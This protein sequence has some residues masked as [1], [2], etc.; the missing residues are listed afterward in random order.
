MCGLVAMICKY[1]SGFTHK[2]LDIFEQL[3]YVDTLRG[4]DSTGVFAVN[5]MGNVGIAKDAVTAENFLKTKE[6]KDIRSHMFREG[7]ALVGH[8]RKATRGEIV[9]D[10]AHPF[11]DDNEKLVLVHNGSYY[12][13]HRKL[14]DTTVDS[15]AITK[16]LA[17]HIDNYAE[18]LRKVNAAYALIFYDT[19]NKKLNIIRN[20]DRPLWQVE[21]DYAYFFCSE[22]W[23]LHGVIARN[24]NKVKEKAAEL[25]PHTLH[26]F[27]LQDDH[28]TNVSSEKLDCTFRSSYNHSEEPGD[29]EQE[30]EY[31]ANLRQGGWNRTHTAWANYG[32]CGNDPV[33]PSKT[34][35]YHRENED[36]LAVATRLC[37]PDNDG[38][39]TLFK[40]EQWRKLDDGVYGK[41]KTI[42]VI[43]DDWIQP[44]NSSFVYLR[45]KTLDTNEAPIIFPVKNSQLE[46]YMDS[47][48]DGTDL[49]FDIEIDR[50]LWKKK[51]TALN[52]GV[53]DINEVFGV[54]YLIGKNHNVIN[55]SNNHGQ[56]H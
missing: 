5:N 53:I 33:G 46:A 30:W 20:N 21:T 39:T 54:V 27:H 25:D 43:V 29:L 13:D 9:N 50:C 3:L 23:M 51:E 1:R 24:G 17:G 42:S 2:D 41:G 34:C 4:D 6:F 28:S 56:A 36:T 8:N 10:N 26:T 16:H 40:Y 48:N 22:P 19:E 45:G 7:W 47:S 38:T 52:R 55:I 37:S 14:A 18:G 31:Y 35:G 32:E 15:E 11:W 44:D 12:G 49:L